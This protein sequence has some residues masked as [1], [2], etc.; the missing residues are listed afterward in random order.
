MLIKVDFSKN[1]FRLLYANLYDRVAAFALANNEPEEAV[2]ARF[3]S[4][5]AGDERVQ[6]LVD[7]D[8]NAQIKAHCLITFNQVTQDSL[9]A[10][11]EQILSDSG[12]GESFAK[13]CIAFLENIPFVTR[14]TMATTEKKYRAFKK[15]YGFEPWKIIMVRE[16]N[17]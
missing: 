3:M 6:L 13:D 14:L 2:K 10:F 9:N 12:H 7:L 17:R 4:L 5:I 16:V 15:K 1:M 8:D 11:V